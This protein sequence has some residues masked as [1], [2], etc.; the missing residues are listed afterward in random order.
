MTGQAGRHGDQSHGR[1]NVGRGSG[2]GD[3]DGALIG[4]SL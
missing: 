2:D 4:A 3:R 1:A